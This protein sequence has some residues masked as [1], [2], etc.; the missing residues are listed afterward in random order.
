MPQLLSTPLTCSFKI[1]KVQIWPRTFSLCIGEQD[2]KQN[3]WYFSHPNLKIGINSNIIAHKL[4]F[5][6]FFF[7]KIPDHQHPSRVKHCVLLYP[8]CILF[9]LTLFWMGYDG[10]GGIYYL[11]LPYPIQNR[12][13]TQKMFQNVK[14]TWAT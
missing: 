7:S 4:G 3:F 2:S 10:M 11:S 13:K 8:R 5:M 14:C 6:L 9:S 1:R 12:A